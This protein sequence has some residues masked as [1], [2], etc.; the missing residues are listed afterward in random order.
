MFSDFKK[1]EIEKTIL[2]FQMFLISG[3]QS[4][5]ILAFLS[6]NGCNQ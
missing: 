6:S 1:L 4:A 5:M 3:S 2:A